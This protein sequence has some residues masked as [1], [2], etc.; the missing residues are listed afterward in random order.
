MSTPAGGGPTGGRTHVAFL[1]RPPDAHQTFTRDTTL[2]LVRW[3]LEMF[4]MNIFAA[5]DWLKFRI[6]GLPWDAR[7]DFNCRCFQLQL[8][9]GSL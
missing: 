5:H 2:G 7:L 8:V 4:W 3:T 6:H 9:W 1:A